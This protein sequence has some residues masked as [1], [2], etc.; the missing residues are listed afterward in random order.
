MS[1]FAPSSSSCAR[2]SIHPRPSLCPNRP[3]RSVR[4]ATSSAEHRRASTRDHWR[5]PVLTGFG[6]RC[7]R[8]TGSWCGASRI[9]RRVPSRSQWLTS[10]ARASRSSPQSGRSAGFRRSDEGPLLF[11]PT[12]AQRDAFVSES[13]GLLDQVKR[14]LE[15]AEAI[16]SSGYLLVID[17]ALAHLALARAEFDAGKQWRGVDRKWAS[18]VGG[19]P[20][21]S[22]RC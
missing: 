1:G 12:A 2:L 8:W 20:S 15:D 11:A 7:P 14:L 10:C 22:R 16:G 21:K 6:I 5:R 18:R 4:L 3:S 19:R 9:C 13:N 17:V